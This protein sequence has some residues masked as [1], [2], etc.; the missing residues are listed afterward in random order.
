M[1]VICGFYSKGISAKMR[2]S[3]AMGQQ[4][5][6]AMVNAIESAEVGAMGEG[7]GHVRDLWILL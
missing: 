5:G 4:L 3:E 2:T 7:A 6:F 1:S